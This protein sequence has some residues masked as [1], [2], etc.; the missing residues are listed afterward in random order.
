MNQ[1]TI[2]MIAQYQNDDNKIKH[3]KV[4]WYVVIIIEDS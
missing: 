1:H 4:K 3:L 2:L